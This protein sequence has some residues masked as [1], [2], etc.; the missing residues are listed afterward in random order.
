MYY[1]CNNKLTGGEHQHFPTSANHK[2]DATIWEH[3]QVWANTSD[4]IK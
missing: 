4:Y 2:F 1:F 3:T